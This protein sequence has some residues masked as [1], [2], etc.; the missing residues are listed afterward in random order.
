M[1]L[2]LQQLIGIWKLLYINVTDP[3]FE[4]NYGPDLFGRIII[5]PE[6]Y[7]NAMITD[8]GPGL[9]TNVTWQNATSAELGVVVQKMTIYEGPVT[10]V[11]QGNLT[12]THTAVQTALNPQWVNT[13]QVRQAVLVETEGKKVL[14]LIPWVVS[15]TPILDPKE[16]ELIDLQN[17]TGTWAPEGIQLTWQRVLPA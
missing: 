6:S 4:I 13:V 17:T 2:E 5:T 15:L 3:A 14:T 9:P 16:I 10:L 11:E 7:F 8:H 12:F 1:R